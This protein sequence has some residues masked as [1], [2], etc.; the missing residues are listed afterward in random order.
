MLEH[1][2]NTV[3]GDEAAQIFALPLVPLDDQLRGPS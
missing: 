1:G 3:S 2:D